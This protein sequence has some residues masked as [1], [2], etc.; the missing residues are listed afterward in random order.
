M[1]V[2]ISITGDG[3]ENLFDYIIFNIIIMQKQRSISNIINID[4]LEKIINIIINNLKVDNKYKVELL[5]NFY[6]DY[7]VQRLIDN[8]FDYFYMKNNTIYLE[9]NISFGKIEFLINKIDLNK[10]I[11]FTIINLLE[12]NIKIKE[13][14]GITIRKDVY[15][16]I[17]NLY[18]RANI[19]YRKLSDAEKN[20]KNNDDNIKLLKKTM[21]EISVLEFNIENSME[22]FEV[23]DLLLYLEEK[24]SGKK[25]DTTKFNI[26]NNYF[27]KEEFNKDLF[28]LN[29]QGVSD[30][31]DNMIKY[32][33]EMIIAKNMNALYYDYLEEYKFY[34]KFYYLL[35][36]KIKKTNDIQ[37]KNKLIETKYQLMKTL[38]IVY[39]NTLFLGKDSS[40]SVL[41]DFQ[42]IYYK[43]FCNSCF[44]V[45]QLLTYEDSDYLN[46]EIKYQNIL[47]ENYIKAYYE[48]TGDKNIE[49]FIKESLSCI[50][51]DISSNML[52]E[53]ITHNKIKK[54]EM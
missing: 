21:L 20:N 4:N 49:N 12:E 38:D 5:D 27:L 25:I 14:Y 11:S 52:E 8:Y 19:L 32:K 42:G 13:L 36:D 54:K 1:Y 28:W 15:N 51:K 30:I 29:I 23:F 47:K 10:D 45:E 31:E 18:K 9:D 22:A 53:I 46:E 50:K 44:F 7:E 16:Y 33:N 6:I 24:V 3:M 39:N 43:M 48:L 34:L 40:T 17:H 41:S 35:I 2:N 37:E 26:E